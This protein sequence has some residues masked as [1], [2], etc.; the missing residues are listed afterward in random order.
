MQDYILAVQREDPNAALSM[1]SEELRE[2]CDPSAVYDGH[3]SLPRDSF[4]IRLERTDEGDDEAVVTIEVTEVD[5][6]GEVPLFGGS[7]NNYDAT[8]HLV[9]EQGEW[10]LS[11]PG[12]PGWWCPHKPTPVPT[13]TSTEEP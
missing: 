9:R 10:R 1:L 13:T 11:D 7:V 6:P 3:F 8:Y 4:S 2:Q 12:W 5:A